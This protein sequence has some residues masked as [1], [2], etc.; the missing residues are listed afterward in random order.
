MARYK[1]WKDFDR[2]WLSAN[3]PKY[4]PTGFHKMKL[5][6]SLHKAVQDSYHRARGR[7]RP[8][9]SQPAFGLNCNTGYDNDDWIVHGDSSAQEAVSNFIMQQLKEWTGQNVNERTSLYGVREYHRGSICGLHVD[10]T[11][12]HA[13]SAIYQ[14][15]QR[16]MDEP[17]ASSY[18]NH[19]GE[20]GEIFLEPGEI[21]MY[22]SASSLHGRH[23]P[24]KGDEFANIFFHFRSP[25]WA[26][27]IK[28]IMGSTYWP[29]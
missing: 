16:G 5:P 7:S 3:I 28:K 14:V 12:T 13:F 8:E 1:A 23:K 10:N 26:P 4:T 17:W 6:E 9:P 19:A 22:E 29:K 20:E 18:V 2:G 24:L 27:T 11:E 21:L 25:E 15:D